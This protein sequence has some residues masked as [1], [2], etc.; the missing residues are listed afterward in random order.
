MEVNTHE[1]LVELLGTYPDGDQEVVISRMEGGKYTIENVATLIGC[2]LDTAVAALGGGLSQL[3]PRLKVRVRSGEGLRSCLHLSAASIR[4]IASASA[5]LDFDPYPVFGS[6]DEDATNG[7]HRGVPVTWPELVVVFVGESPSSRE[8]A[9][10]SRVGCQWYT[11]D[12]LQATVTEAIARAAQQVGEGMALWDPQVGV[13]LSSGRGI[14]AVL[15]LSADVIQA[16][17]SCGAS[18]DFDPYV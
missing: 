8:E 11:L 16:M 6:V 15:Y 2:V 5:S 17:A 13:R 14:R 4:Q 3:R 9:V 1:V 18:L 12:D 7:A 10:L